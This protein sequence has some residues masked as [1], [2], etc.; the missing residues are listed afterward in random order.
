MLLQPVNWCR[1]PLHWGP[2]RHFQSSPWLESSWWRRLLRRN[3]QPGP[4]LK[5]RIFLPC[6]SRRPACS[7]CASLL[8]S[9]RW[10]S[11]L[12]NFQPHNETET[13]SFFFSPVH[14]RLRLGWDVRLLIPWYNIYL[15]IYIYIYY[16][17]RR[18]C[19]KPNPIYP[20]LLARLQV[21][22]W[23]TRQDSANWV[24]ALT[25]RR[26]CVCVGSWVM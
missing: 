5:P 3:E 4:R 2:S 15:D 26:K 21:P 1:L 8:A 18:K 7:S 10:D 14:N 6:C 24:Y 16:F 19:E 9:R 23:L 22:I 12:K 11:L 13:A 17:S 25:Q 20:E